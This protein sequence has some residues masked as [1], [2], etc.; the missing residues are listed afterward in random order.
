[1]V[2]RKLHLKFDC[3]YNFV[4]GG[5]DDGDGEKESQGVNIGD[6][7]E[8]PDRINIFRCSPLDTTTEVSEGLDLKDP[9]HHHLAF[10][11][12]YITFIYCLT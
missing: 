10:N 5:R 7:R 8:M 1:M 3:F 11:S 12:I 2:V 9:T 6:V 4:V